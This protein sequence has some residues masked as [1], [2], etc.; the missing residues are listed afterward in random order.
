MKGY[1]GVGPRGG[2][3]LYKTFLSTPWALLGRGYLYVRDA[4]GYL[5]KSR[6]KKRIIIK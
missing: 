1:Q 3:S 4:R 2:A 6:V 5:K